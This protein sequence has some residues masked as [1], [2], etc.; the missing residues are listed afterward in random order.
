MAAS[1]SEQ[2]MLLS[3]HAISAGKIQQPYRELNVIA[4]RLFD[5][6]LVCSRYAPVQRL[7]RVVP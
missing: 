3:Q 2:Q 6:W 5:L 7:F 1:L 4:I